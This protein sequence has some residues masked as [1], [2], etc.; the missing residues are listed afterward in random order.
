MSQKITLWISLL[1]LILASC[2]TQ[3]LPT[4]TSTPAPAATPTTISSSNKTLEQPKCIAASAKPTPNPTLEA[5]L[6]PPTE[7]DWSLGPDDAYVTLIEYS[8]FECPSCAAMEPILAQLKKRF[9]DDLRVVFRHYPLNIHEKAQITARAAE[10]AGLQGKFWEMHDVLF[11]QRSEW[12]DLTEDEFTRWVAEEAEAL[13]LER[14]QFLKDMNSA[15]IVA[16]VQKSWEQNYAI[17]MPGTPFLVLNGLPYNGPTDYANLAATIDLILMERRQFTECP[18]MVIAPNKQYIAVIHT[19]KGDITVELFADKAPLA[20][21]SF[22]FLARQGWFDGVTFHRVIPGF[23]AQAGDPSGTGFGGPGYLFDNEISPELTF[24]G[25][26]VFAMANAGPGSNGSQFF[27][28]YAAVP[29]LNGGYT[30]FGRVIEGMDV[31]EKL[32]PRDPSQSM[33]LPPGDRI[34]SIDIIE[35]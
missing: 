6:P 26:G 5:I 27:I 22:V 2:T 31:A 32:T 35:Q 17:G 19:E 20:V 23:V 18:P 11:A 4:P 34:L 29:R 7:K 9:A 24:D 15:E 3:A 10:A 16:L 12:V 14:E 1:T 13:G 28:T 30:I 8:D 33:D 21:N 25:P